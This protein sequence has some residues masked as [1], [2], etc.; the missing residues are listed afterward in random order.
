MA[1]ECVKIDLNTAD[2]GTLIEMP[3]VGRWLAKGIIDARPF[4]SVDDLERVNGIGPD[5]IA[6]LRSLVWVSEA[7]ETETEMQPSAPLAEGEP[8]PSEAVV[9]QDAPAEEGLPNEAAEPTP[10]TQET[11]G[12]EDVPQP[13]AAV[14]IEA[15]ETLA[16][17]D[18]PEEKASVEAELPE[19]KDR[20]SSEASAVLTRAQGCRF[21]L[22][23][24][25]SAAALALVLSLG[26]LSNLNDGSLQYVTSSE[27]F[28][29]RQEIDLLNTRADTLAGELQGLRKRV[30]NLDT[31]SQRVT[32]QG[33]TLET[34][35]TAI[36]QLG[37]DVAA[38]SLQLDTLSEKMEP[39]AAQVDALEAQGERFQTF[40]TGLRDLMSGVFSL[41]EQK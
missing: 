39:I 2:V 24:V 36:S 19:P 28:R 18:V 10:E 13:D 11:T 34:Q 14:T 40:L 15:E 37:E 6:R 8:E 33:E 17:E 9:P 38:A 35:T 31:L 29:V 4:A 30:D 5:S 21:A 27:M 32:V 7:S 12:N 1:D 16:K 23:S 3:G 25:L 41:E 22:L 26:F 20:V